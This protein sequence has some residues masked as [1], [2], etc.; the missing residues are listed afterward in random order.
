M[1]SPDPGPVVLPPPAPAASAPRPAWRGALLYPFRRPLR[2]LMALVLL[3]VVGFVAF[4][5]GFTVWLDYHRRAARDDLDR[6]RLPQAQTHL[7]ACLWAAPHDPDCLFLAARAARRSGAFERADDFLNQYEAARG[8]DD[9]GLILERVLLQAQRGEIKRVSAFCDARVRDGHAD[10]PLILEALTAGFLRTYN[11]ADAQSALDAWKKLRPDD[12]QAAI[13]QGALYDLQ[14]RTTDAIAQYRRAVELDPD[15]P[16]ALS[17]FSGALVQTFQAD[18]AL[19]YL[20]RL[21]RLTPKDPRVLVLMAQCHILLKHNPEAAALLDEALAADP[22]QVEALTLRGKVAIED[23]RLEDAEKL[24]RKAVERDPGRYDARYQLVTCLS[25]LGR[26][27]ES[28]AEQ[29]RLDQLEADMKEIHEI[30]TRRMQAS[31]F[32]PEPRYR[33]GMIALRAGV[34][35]EGLRWMESALEVDPNYVEAHNVLARYYQDVEVNPARAAFHL[36]KAKAAAAAKPP[37]SKHGNNDKPG[38]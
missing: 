8:K 10:A 13:F 1:S 30:V 6:Y 31:P 18:E 34:L 14:D 5:V 36:D 27:A 17:R 3:G 19:G 7:T 11:L 37:D 12:V 15:N 33:A 24:F 2:S 25:S 9:Q 23:G 29:Q 4:E 16:E 28:K 22:N 32:D 20:V 26:D 21:R 35:K 38:N